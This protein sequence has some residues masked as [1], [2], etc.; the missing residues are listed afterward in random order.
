MDVKAAS[1]DASLPLPT[2]FM[3]TEATRVV[4]KIEV[5]TEEEFSEYNFD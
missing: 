2:K 3:E 1:F 5:L 4:N